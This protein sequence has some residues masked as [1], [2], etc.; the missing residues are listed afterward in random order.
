MPATSAPSSDLDESDRDHR[1]APGHQ[2]LAA[3]AAGLQQLGLG[4]AEAED[5]P[6]DQ[7]EQDEGEAQVD[8]EAVRGHALHAGREARGDHPPADRPLQPA[9]DAD[10]EEARGPAGRDAA[11]DGEEQEA[12]GPDSTDGTAELAVAPLPPVD[13]LEGIERHS[14]VEGGVLR[15]GLVLVE[16]GLP[17]GVAGR[18][19]RAGDRPPLGDRKAGVGEAGEAADADH[20]DD[21]REENR[22]PDGDAAAV[23]LDARG[24]GRRRGRGVLLAHLLED[25]AGLGHAPSGRGVYAPARGAASGF[26]RTARRRGARRRWRS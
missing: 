1:G 19:Q 26:V 5:V 2:R 11:A 25:A 21:E 8:R 16:R 20:R 13:A 14:L 22:K 17:C 10:A 6:G 15:G 18:G 3:L 23:G 12:E 24:L 4:A 9:E 7:A